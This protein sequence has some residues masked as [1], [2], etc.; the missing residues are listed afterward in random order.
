MSFI[1]GFVF[2]LL[3]AMSLPVRVTDFLKLK[4]LCLYNKI[5]KSL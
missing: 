4:M 3:L 5:F 2:G 1:L